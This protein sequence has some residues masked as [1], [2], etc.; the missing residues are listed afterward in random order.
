[1][2]AEGGG[3]PCEKLLPEEAAGLLAGFFCGGLL[4]ATIFL[5]YTK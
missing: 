1:M 4:A 2:G 5:V 3:C